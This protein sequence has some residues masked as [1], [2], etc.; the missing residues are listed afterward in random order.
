MLY[1]HREKHTVYEMA[2]FESSEDALDGLDENITRLPTVVSGAK[3]KIFQEK[4]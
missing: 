1:P 4:V 3:S 2:L